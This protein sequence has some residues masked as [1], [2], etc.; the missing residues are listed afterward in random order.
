[1]LRALL[2]CGIRPDLVVGTSV[3]AMHG[4]AVAAAADL[5]TVHALEQAWVNLNAERLFASPL[6]GAAGLVRTRTHLH[7]NR[8]LRRLVERVLPV[9][10]FEDLAVPFQCVA[11]CV[12]RAAEHWFSS[13][14]LV[15]A[16]LASA[17]V[18][19]LFPAVEIGG[20]HFLDGGIV[21]SIPVERA[22]ELGATE[23][24][25]LQVG[26]VEWPLTAP[27]N[28]WQVAT[29]SFEIARRHRFAHDMA[30][31]PSGV[32][33]HVLPS[34]QPRTV[35]VDA[36]SARRYRD[37]DVARLRIQRAHRASRR[38]LDAVGLGG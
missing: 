30:A 19:G 14:P 31:L 2:E 17:A 37:A 29:V 9:E 34:G 35:R 15:D 25:V 13:G 3:G 16:I 24:Y 20:E 22:V 12:E 23:I 32:V 38:Y 5:D 8:S 10:T 7:S 28:L 11:A 21:N 26:R 1:M 6:M 18:P 4:A 33:A 36:G 27:R